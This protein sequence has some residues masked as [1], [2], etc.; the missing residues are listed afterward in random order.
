MVLIHVHLQPGALVALE[1]VGKGERRCRIRDS[2]VVAPD[3]MLAL[4]LAYM[5]GLTR[6]L[7]PGYAGK[8]REHEGISDL[9]R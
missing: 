3:P 4:S 9:R 2:E 8:R 7:Q 6:L 5:V 1:R